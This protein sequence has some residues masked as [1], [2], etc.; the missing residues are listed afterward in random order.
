MSHQEADVAF[1][2]YVVKALV[3]H[4]SDV[5]V[6]RVVDE[7]GVLITLDVNPGDMGKIIGRDGNTAKAIRTLLRVVG[8]KNNARVNLKIN[9]PDGS[10]K[11]V[12]LKSVDEVIEALSA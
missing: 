9:E 6:N 4:P 11:T 7:M 3:D 5:K 10:K 8:M 12:V 1:L 2:E